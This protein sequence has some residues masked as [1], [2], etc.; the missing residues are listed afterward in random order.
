MN[1]YQTGGH[2]KMN[3]TLFIVGGNIVES[4]DEIFSALIERAGG[5]NGKFAFIVTASGEGPDELFRSYAADFKALGV[6][7]ENCLLIPLYA[8]HVRDERGYNAMTG[9]ADGLCELM[10]GVTGVWFTGGDQYFTAQCFL[11]ADG[12]DTKLLTRLHEFYQNGGVIGGSSAGAAIMSRVMIGEGSNRGIIS[13][14]V[15]FGYEGYDEL[16]EEDNPCVP[17][18][19]TRG[20]GFFAEGVVDQHFNRRPR[21]LRAIEACLSNTE[22][23][24]M[25]FAVSEDTALVYHAGEI[26]VLGSACVYIIDCRNAV[27]SGLGNYEGIM[28]SSIQKGDLYNARTGKITLARKEN[29][30]QYEYKSDYVSGGITGSRAF[31]EMIDKYLFCCKREN[32]YFCARRN[33]PY[34]KGAAVYEADDKTYLVVPEYFIG[35]NTTGYMG[36]CASFAN[37]ELAVKTVEV[38]L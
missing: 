1:D 37:L 34:F 22:N 38:E 20:L 9:D 11:R 16:M 6:P 24:R 8:Q 5:P 31:D 25:G 7:E 18:M 35:E 36:E 32:L 29:Y 2:I 21:L 13:R 12:S 33:K 26:E 15:R 19:I 27:K 28:L 4:A 30:K 14:G 10:D 23:T 3:G 17:L